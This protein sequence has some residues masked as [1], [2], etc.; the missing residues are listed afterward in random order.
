VTGPVDVAHLVP[1]AEQALLLSVAISLPVV[2]ALALASLVVS[3][4][5]ASTQITDTTLAHLPRFLVAV[6]VLAILGRWMGSEVAA[7]A[8]RMF[9]GNA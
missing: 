7:F 6:V 5:Q 4:L 2:G 9:S 8:V 3:V 1:L